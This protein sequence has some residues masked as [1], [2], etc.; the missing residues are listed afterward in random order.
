MSGAPDEQGR[1][2]GQVQ[3][4]SVDAS[5]MT[6]RL[7]ARVAEGFSLTLASRQRVTLVAKMI[8]PS[9]D[10]TRFDGASV[11]RLPSM[12]SPSPDVVVQLSVSETPDWFDSALVCLQDPSWCAQPLP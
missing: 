6:V 8:S 10:Q 5:K 1:R 4:H 2:L 12:A 3:V 7:E 9:Q 11:M